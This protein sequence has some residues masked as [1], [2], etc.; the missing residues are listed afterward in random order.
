[1]FRIDTRAVGTTRV[2]VRVSGRLTGERAVQLA[3]EVAPHADAQ[4]TVHLDLCGLTGLDQE[5]L[6]TLLRLT[7][8]RVH[9]A[10]CPAFLTLWLR[11]EHR[12]RIREAS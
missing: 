5:G 9:V 8:G 12:S 7:D 3:A 4:R 1:M 11:A 10:N 6:S 2:D